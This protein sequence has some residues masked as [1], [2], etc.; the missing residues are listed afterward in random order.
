MTDLLGGHVKVTFEAMTVTADHVREGKLRAIAVASQTRFAG[1]F[2]AHGRLVPVWDLP[3]ET[4]AAEWEEP[5][6]GF[7]K[8]YAD[9]L[10]DGTPLDAT[11]RRA[12]QGLLGRQLT[13]R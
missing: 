13:L 6:A 7:A 8:R 1:M 12:R 9:A 4:P 10:T 11:G 3:V 5:L 2:R